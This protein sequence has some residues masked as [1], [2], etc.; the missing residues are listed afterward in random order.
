MMHRTHHQC[1]V[2]RIT[3]DASLYIN[4]HSRY[5]PSKNRP[6]MHDLKIEERGDKRRFHFYLSH[7]VLKVRSTYLI[8]GLYV[9][10]LAGQRGHRA[11]SSSRGEK[12]PALTTA[13]HS[14]RSLGRPLGR[15]LRSVGGGSRALAVARGCFA[16]S[17]SSRCG[18]A[19]P[20]PPT[21]APAVLPQLHR[22]VEI[23]DRTSLGVASA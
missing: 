2:G 20:P 4:R 14:L 5:R 12:A 6:G 21:A 10:G 16:A 3:H 15:G 18:L 7:V 17:I 22:K 11:R 23:D 8:V 1:P 19:L 9:P 13:C